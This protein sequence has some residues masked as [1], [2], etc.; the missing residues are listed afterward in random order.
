MNGQIRGKLDLKVFVLYV[1]SRINAPVELSMIYE[2]CRTDNGVEYFEFTDCL[3]EL[4][5]S[6]QLSENMCFFNITE[7]GR[8]NAEAVIDSLPASVRNNADR[9]IRKYEP[10]INIQSAIT[11]ELLDADVG[12]NV[13]LKLEDDLG[14]QA[15][16]II[17][18]TDEKQAKNMM[19]NFRLHSE[20]IIKTITKELLK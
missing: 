19:V 10:E 9:C 2:I 18:C 5:D 8:R 15:D 12:Y 4:V 6:G 11:T 7:N 20:K 16:I 13:H 17:R 14:P 3:G 1:M